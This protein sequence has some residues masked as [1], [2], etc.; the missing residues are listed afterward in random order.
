MEVLMARP[1]H[2]VSAKP[3][4]F[5]LAAAVSLAFAGPLAAPLRAQDVPPEVENAKHSAEGRIIGDGVYVRS[6]AGDNYY[7]TMKVNSG[8][9]VTVVG[10][11]FDWL[12]I[13]PPDGSFCYVA[14]AFVDRGA[15]DTGKVNRDGINV[16]AGSTVNAMK[17]TVQAT[18]SSGQEVKILGEQDEYYK[19]APPAD[20]F[21]YVKKDF[22]D[23]VRAIP[24][25]APAK[26][27]DPI[28]QDKPLT[29]PGDG[30]PP[31]VPPVDGGTEAPNPPIA[32]GNRPP[33]EVPTTQTLDKQVAVAKPSTQP[34][35][36]EL[37]FDKLEADFL[38]ASA[39]PI[40][41]QPVTELLGGYQ[42]LATD[43]QLPESMRRIADFRTQTL[44]ARAEAREQF[45]VVQKQQ[46]EAKKK[47]IALKSEQEEIAQQ[48]KKTD[49]L[50]YT[51]VGVLR[52]SSIQRG[53]EVMYRL[54][55]PQN[56]RTVCYIRS[57]DAKYAT[58]I[59]QFIGVKGDL[60]T[61]PQLNLKVVTATEFAPVDPNQ[62]F[63]GVGAQIVPPSLLPQ[64]ALQASTTEQ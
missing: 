30:A 55:D 47:Q 36:V 61:E 39:K 35:T 3:G 15:G 18:L 6:G 38:A 50:V 27:E 46:E 28:A 23:F 57:T 40:E 54:T 5:A 34:S 63:R 62:V 10:V 31:A 53:A 51:A 45:A 42:K 52:P 22:V 16:R 20:A 32:E 4:L 19:I 2:F 43:T 49:V 9:P 8:T 24:T 21:V 44:K 14:K 48:I 7:P 33:G 26:P 12:K 58:L 60:I 1:F 64:A 13:T 17:T 29:A 37:Q 11:K 56:G 25:P 41:Q 59:G